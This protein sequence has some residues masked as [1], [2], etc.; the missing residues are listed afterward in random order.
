MIDLRHGSGRR[1]AGAAALRLRLGG[2]GEPARD[3]FS[4]LAA[5][6]TEDF[7]PQLSPELGKREL[8]GVGGLQQFTQ[9]LESDLSEFRYDAAEFIPAADGTVVVLGTIR[10]AGR[11]SQMPLSGNFGHVWTLR[12][13]KAA[14]VRAYR[15]RATAQESADL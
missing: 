3:G 9:A 2:G 4:E 10:A 8:D 1:R 15:D 14:A 7:S 5:L 12:D 11:A 6:V 13:G